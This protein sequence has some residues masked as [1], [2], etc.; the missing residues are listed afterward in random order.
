MSNGQWR[1]R[2]RSRFVRIRRGLI[3]RNRWCYE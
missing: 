1:Q 2:G 3:R